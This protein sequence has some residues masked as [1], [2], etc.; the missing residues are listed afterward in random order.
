M[1]DKEMSCEEIREKEENH[2][3][4]SDIVIK[5]ETDVS[6]VLKGLKAIRQEVRKTMR[7]IKELEE[8]K[9]IKINGKEVAEKVYKDV[10]KLQDKD[11]RFR[12]VF[13]NND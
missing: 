12:E 13:G 7:A 9:T 3:N 11:K 8:G 6:S 10:T 2:F 4:I 1:A 5:I